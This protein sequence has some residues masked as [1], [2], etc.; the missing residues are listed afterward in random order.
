MFHLKRTIHFTLLAALSFAGAAQ[1]ATYYVATTGSNGYA[2][3]QAQNQSTP[4]Q[5]IQAGVSCLASGDTLI[6]KAGTYTSNVTGGM[7]Q[8]PIAGNAA[9]GAYTT[10]K[11]DPSG[12]RPIL[13]MQ[14]DATGT[15]QIGLYC[16]NG[17]ACHHIQVEYFDMRNGYA[18]SY[19]QGTDATGYPH[20]VNFINNIIHDTSNEGI[21]AW[22]STDGTQGGSHII[23][24]NE[25]YNI[26]IYDPGY[27]PGHNTIYSPCSNTLIEN[28]TFHNL[29]HGIGIWKSNHQMSNV[30]VKNNVF[31]NIGRM[32]IDRWQIGANGSNAIHI[33]VPGVGHI[34]YNNIIYNSGSA[35]YP[36]LFKGVR[37]GTQ[38]TI[39]TNV[40]VAN[41]TIYNL[42]NASGYAILDQVGGST[43]N[44]NIAYQAALG[45]S[46][47]TQSYNLLT[48]PSFV[49]AASANFHLQ[50]GSAAIDK[51]LTMPSVKVDYEG[52]PR[53][54]G[55]A[56]DIGAYEGSG[57]LAPAPPKNLTVR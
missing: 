12:P 22:C 29:I 23:R 2:C 13:S 37:I 38:A 42:F 28:N 47:G 48:N 51:G 56:Y 53:P 4:K 36:T 10:I 52:A 34:I 15:F 25:F 50:S 44:N 30:T 1:A 8:D 31:Y 16:T 35:A 55:A 26:G 33:S 11:G 49:D 17:A 32:D 43:I 27:V 18:G 39:A 3:A 6:V 40:L 14:H 19:L 45:I 7:I 5:T 20:H 41:N 21:E 46:G 57:G 54:Q 24:G 9:T